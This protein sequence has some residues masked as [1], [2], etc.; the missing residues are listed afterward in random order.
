MKHSVST[1]GS[2]FTLIELLVVIAILAVLAVVVVLTLNPAGLLQESRDANRL[3]DMATLNSAIGY[4]LAD[5]SGESLG[6][7]NTVYVSVPDP[8]ATTTAGSDCTALGLPSLSGSGATYHCAASSTWRK[9]DGTGW[10]PVNLSANTFGSSLSQ[11]PIDP[12]NATGTGLYYTYATNGSQLE[13]TSIFESQK[14]KTQ[15]ATNPMVP[16]YPEVNGKGSNL[17]LNPLYNSS[18][19]VGW[20]PMDEGSGTVAQDLSGNGNNGTW[21][22]STPYYAGGKVGPYARNFNGS[23]DYKDGSTLGSITIP[24]SGI[25]LK[26]IGSR[27]E[28]GANLF[29]GLIDD[30]RIYCGFRRRGPGP[31]Q[32]HQVAALKSARA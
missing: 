12:I 7:A 24:H 6:S 25:T 31:L 3:Q 22:G 20:W 28:T 4:S 16:G 5:N 14:Y 21:N 29:P 8:T 11:L 15:Y 18:G 19:L 13:V 1:K 9:T 23:N 30:V 27:G 32:C 17:S 26:R 2:G 10:V